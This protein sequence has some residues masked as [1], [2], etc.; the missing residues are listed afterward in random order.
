MKTILKTFVIFLLSLLFFACSGCKK[1]LSPI[2]DKKKE[3]LCQITDTTSHDITW[4]V[5]TLGVFPSVLYDVSSID[6]NN[7]W[8]VGEIWTP[9]KDTVWNT[10]N[11]KNNAVKWNGNEYEYYQLVSEVYGG[12]QGI[13]YLQT[14]L[15]F[16]ED[17][18]WL[19]SSSSYLYWDGK[20]WETQYI[21]NR[22]GGIKAVWGISS[23]DF[24]IVGS[25][26]SITHYDG[27]SFSLMESGTNISLFEIK[28]YIDPQTGKQHVWVLGYEA[29]NSVV[30]KLENGKWINVW[31]MDLLQNGFRF[32]HALFIDNSKTLVM[33]VWSGMEQKGRL[34]CFNQYDF[35]ENKLLIEH[36]TFTRGMGG[37]GINDLF[38]G[39]AFYRVEH[40]NGSAVYLYDNL[41]GGG[42]QIKTI[43]QGNSIYICGDTGSQQAK[44]IHG[45]R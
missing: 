43:F 30:L 9:E 40:F 32:P 3:E 37:S 33:D 28:G 21:S 5:D 12:G 13:Q 23:N 7:V 26:G 8:A 1:D 35:T 4:R 42:T 14:L 22:Q 41:I 2:D 27:A 45:K 44:L 17:D 24:Y 19:F 20:N 34:Y 38:I 18:I 10:E 29:G 25:N 11:T 6:N 15:T 16:A 36:S 31:D 39:G